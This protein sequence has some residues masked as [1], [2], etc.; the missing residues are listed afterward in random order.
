MKLLT[1]LLIACLEFACLTHRSGANDNGELDSTSKLLETKNSSEFGD[2]MRELLNGATGKE[3]DLL[4]SSDND[5]VALQAA[6]ERI[7]Q[8]MEGKDFTESPPRA[9]NIRPELKQRF[10]GFVAGRLRVTAPSWWSKRVEHLQ[11]MHPAFM[12]ID[13]RDRSVATSIKP[14]MKEID[15]YLFPDRVD[16]ANVSNNGMEL[17]I[18]SKN[19]SIPSLLLE[20]AQEQIEIRVMDI[21]KANNEKLIVAPHFD[22]RG[23]FPVFAV[24]QTS[25]DILWQ[26][27][28]FCE[29]IVVPGGTGIASGHWTEMIV[30][31]QNRVVIFG[32]CD[33]SVYIEAFDIDTGKPA[34]RF[35]TSY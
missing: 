31:S 21:V 17:S 1:F 9:K 19:A 25:G 27:D 23:H 18:D 24:N 13:Q 22:M 15:G 28:V 14:V 34:F 16:S 30:D 32:A 10:L 2:M 8:T 7:R 5:G 35:S 20:K 4:E 33:Q 6:W 3:L 11:Y 12:T 26:A 29:N